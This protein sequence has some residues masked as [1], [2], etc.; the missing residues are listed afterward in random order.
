M[1]HDQHSELPIWVSFLLEL[2]VEDYDQ[3]TRQE[4][5]WRTYLIKWS[6]PYYKLLLLCSSRGSL[7]YTQGTLRKQSVKT[8]AG[9]ALADDAEISAI[10]GYAD[11]Q[12]CAYICA[13]LSS[14]AHHPH[15][16]IY[17]CIWLYMHIYANICAYICI[18][19]WVFKE[20]NSFS[21]MGENGQGERMRRKKT[22]FC[23]I[24]PNTL[25]LHLQQSMQMKNIKLF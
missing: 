8:G 9:H 11:M 18:E 23:C 10:C 20:Q 21:P 22:H 16:R 13:S 14:D 5:I 19:H 1:C 25:H 6:F 12:I 3:E 4:L 7:L 24:D 15:K 2:K 17:G